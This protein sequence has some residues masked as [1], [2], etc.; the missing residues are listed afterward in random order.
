MPRQYRGAPFY[1]CTYKGQYYTEKQCDGETVQEP[2][3]K[4]KLYNKPK[5]NMSRARLLSWANRFKYR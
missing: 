4:A 5:H 2:P 3:K 1:F